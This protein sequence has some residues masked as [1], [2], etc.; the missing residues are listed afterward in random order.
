[1]PTPKEANLPCVKVFETHPNKAD[2]NL[3][4]I[5]LNHSNLEVTPKESL[6]KLKT[7]A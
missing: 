4:K 1:M 7:A 5:K 6:R 3:R 2:R